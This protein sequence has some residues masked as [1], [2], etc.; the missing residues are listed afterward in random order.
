MRIEP[1]HSLAGATK[2]ASKGSQLRESAK[3]DRAE[4][5]ASDNLVRK[6]DETPEVRAAAVARA[7]ALL[8]NPDYPDDATLR[9]VS[10]T[11]A[12]HLASMAGEK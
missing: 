2:L 8:A 1:K 3:T 4:F 9:E 11:L 12:A 10:K 7:K 6:L 5:A